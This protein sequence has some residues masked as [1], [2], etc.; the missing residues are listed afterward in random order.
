MSSEGPAL[1]GGTEP[2]AEKTPP[3]AR[4]AWRWTTPGLWLVRGWRNMGERQRIML[5]AV[6][7]GIAG[8]LVACGYRYI[9]M[10]GADWLDPAASGLPFWLGVILTV[11]VPA[12]GAGLAGLLIHTMHLGG[13]SHG[14]PAIIR[15]VTTGNVAKFHKRYGAKSLLS[16]LVIASGGS[17]G[18]EGPIAELGA[19]V[20]QA[21]VPIAHLRKREQPVLVGCGIAGAIAAI[22]NAPLG[23][24]FFALEIILKDFGLSTAAAAVLAAVA[25][26]AMSRIFFGQ[27]PAFGGMWSEHAS[28]TE[29]P[30]FLILGILCGLASVAFIKSVHLTTKHMPAILRGRWYAPAAG[31][32]LVGLMA[33]AFPDVRGEGYEFINNVVH[34]KDLSPLLWLLVFA[35]IL[36]TSLTL[37]TGAP[38]GSFAPSLFIGAALG[39]AFAHLCGWVAGPETAITLRA[40]PLAAMAAMIA[41]V[42]QAPITGT[43][44]LFDITGGSY[45][46]VLAA[47]IAIAASSVV[48][49]LLRTPSI[50]TVTLLGAGFDPDL[51]RTA[52]ALSGLT[53]A[54]A[55]IRPPILRGDERLR[56][57]LHKFADSGLDVL[58]VVPASGKLIGMVALSDIKSGLLSPE[59]G[60]LMIASELATPVR[61]ALEPTD[62]LVEAFLLMRRLGG[63]AVPVF[64]G[65]GPK[66]PFA[67]F[68]TREELANAICGI[69]ME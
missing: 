18:P 43:L 23:G 6:P 30:L 35:K 59:M 11:L 24:V 8:G 63:D 57:V 2:A 47:L 60:D 55:M 50:Y 27:A 48:T 53:V 7:V 67:G 4:E 64:H 32:L 41:G 17:A 51:A 10:V 58:P 29:L 49:A 39:G 19:G 45:E 26:G 3:P 62:S 38:G 61:G 28:L 34:L 21:F 68:I 65:R 52:T 13:E 31:G 36:A 69:Q 22:F 9:V 20:G 16:M 40:F 15:S 37:G 12:A 25:G 44:I 14:V 42:F 1:A 33:L 56:D 66:A 5:L 54:D 46:V